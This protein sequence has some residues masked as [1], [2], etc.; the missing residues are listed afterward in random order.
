MSVQPVQDTR[1]ETD[2]DL[3]SDETLENPFPYYR[4]LR[5]IGPAAYMSKYGFW[6]IGRYDVVKSALADWETFS[7][8]H[9]GGIAMNDGTNQAWHG[10]PLNT[11]PPEHAGRRKVLD[12]ALRPRHLRS[13]LPDIEQRAEVVVEK[14]LERGEFDG[15]QDFARDLPLHIVMDLIGWPQD[16]RETMLDWADGAFN[17]AGPAGNQRML[18]SL[19]R[20]A[21]GMDYLTNT[22]TKDTIAPNSFGSVVFDAAE[23]GELPKELVP[24]TLA[25]YLNAALDT[26]I[27]A[28]GSLLW[29]FA[30]HPDQWKLVH[31]DPSLVP[32]A[33]LEGVRMESPAQLFSRSTTRDVD[34]GEGCI[35][36]ANTRVVHSYQA[37]N[38]DE[39]H[40]VD[41][42]RFDVTRNPTDNLAFDYGTHACPGRTLATMEGHA[43]FTA[44]AKKV[45]SIELTGEPTRTL[46]NITR[47]FNT[48][49]LRIVAA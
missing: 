9:L 10:S 23:R 25:G 48:L 28:V 29:L 11:D 22:V 47:G 19:P 12:D 27:N 7:S 41:P 8:A 33:F 13:A 3:W 36:P 2:I 4:K 21:A 24:I 17:A 30:T 35:I 43:L 14:L 5:D 31:E 44:L 18:D 37:A 45:R 16:G 6:F 15:V 32:S 42:D 46:N 39:R 40:F 49:P 20:L 1:F 38:R 34:L 26:T